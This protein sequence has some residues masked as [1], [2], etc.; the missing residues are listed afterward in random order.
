MRYNEWTIDQTKYIYVKVLQTH[1]IL[2]C[3]LGM[4]ES[5]RGRLVMTWYVQADNNSE[6]H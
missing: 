5:Y 4:Q 6:Q 1:R 2:L 3:A